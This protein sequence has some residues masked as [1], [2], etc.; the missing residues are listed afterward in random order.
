MKKKAT[1]HKG[2]LY[3]NDKQPKL[4]ENPKISLIINTNNSSEVMRMIMNDLVFIS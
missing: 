4:I 3:I 2:K 1:T